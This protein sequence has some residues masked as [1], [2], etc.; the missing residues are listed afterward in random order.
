[1][2]NK[3]YSHFTVILP[4]LNE[5]GTIG[6]MIGRIGTEYPRMRIIVVDDGSSDGTRGTVRR[7]SRSNKRV[8]LMDRHAEG[9][10]RGLT[11]SIVDGMRRSTTEYAIVMDSDMQHPLEKIREIARQLERGCDIVVAERESVTD[12]APYRQLISRA[13]MRV[14]LMVLDAEG[15]ETC[16]DVFSGFFGVRR[17]MF[18]RVYSRNS[19]RFVGEGYKVL[20]DFLKCVDRGSLRIGRVPYVFHVR[21]FGRSKAGYRQGLALLKSFLS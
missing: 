6:A 5:N 12:W 15:S 19:S 13:L 9:K 20:F 3:D 18:M 2:G 4:T 7:L 11:A 10:R 21:E 1:M 17:S 14:G 16:K 8:T